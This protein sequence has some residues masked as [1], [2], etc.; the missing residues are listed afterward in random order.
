MA[1]SEGFLWEEFGIP[2]K[3]LVW[4]MICLFFGGRG[5][6]KVGGGELVLVLRD[7]G[8]I[9]FKVPC[10]CFLVGSGLVMLLPGGFWMVTVISCAH[11]LAGVCQN[12]LEVRFGSEIVVGQCGS[13]IVG[14]WCEGAL[15]VV[16]EAP[17]CSARARSIFFCGFDLFSPAIKHKLQSVP[18]GNYQKPDAMPPLPS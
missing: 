3:G 11:I 17:L 9:W 16:G 8:K 7:E 14:K 10:C 4:G 2:P 18:K 6:P 12:S 1:W 5:G 13:F 15:A